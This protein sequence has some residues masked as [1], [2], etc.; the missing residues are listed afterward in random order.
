VQRGIEIG[1][2]VLA[3]HEKPKQFGGV[4]I[5]SADDA[6]IAKA[7]GYDNKTP[8]ADGA[9][10]GADCQINGGDPAEIKCSDESGA[11]S[12]SSSREY[13]MVEVDPSSNDVSVATINDRTDI[14]S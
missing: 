13:V 11:F 7:A 8:T 10:D 5:T 4:D 6:D 12:N 3:A 14:N 2:N 1:N 9:G